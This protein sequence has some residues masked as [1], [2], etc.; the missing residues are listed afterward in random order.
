[1]PVGRQLA[2]FIR[3]LA[4]HFAAL[5]DW[6]EKHPVTTSII[7]FI[8]GGISVWISTEIRERIRHKITIKPNGFKSDTVQGERLVTLV[9]F[10]I[11]ILN[12]SRVQVS[13][14]DF[15]LELPEEIKS[16]RKSDDCQ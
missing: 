14:Q 4:H 9:K 2:S 11:K 3:P 6:I 8:A 10:N 12:R 7:L 13:L 15:Y 1:M 5:V 16:L